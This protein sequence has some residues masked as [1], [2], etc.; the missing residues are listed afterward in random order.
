M[1]Q[2]TLSAEERS[3]RVQRW[4]GTLGLRFNGT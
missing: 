3:R 2:M 1:V 4:Q